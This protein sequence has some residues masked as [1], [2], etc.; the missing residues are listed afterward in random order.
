MLTQPNGRLIQ[1]PKTFPLRIVATSHATAL[2]IRDAM[3]EVTQLRKP[4]YGLR[5]LSKCPIKV[6][7]TVIHAIAYN[8]DGDE[9]GFR[10]NSD[11]INDVWVQLP[12]VSIRLTA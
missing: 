12:I 7:G 4:W 5:L 3:I 1:W 11:I 9:D 6:D 2:S 10:A 8:F